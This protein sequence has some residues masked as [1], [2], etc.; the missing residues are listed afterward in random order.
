MTFSAIFRTK[1]FMHTKKLKFTLLIGRLNKQPDD[2]RAHTRVCAVLRYCV[3]VRVLVEWE[4]RGKAI[5]EWN[6]GKSKFIGI[7][8][9]ASRT[10]WTRR[11]VWVNVRVGW[12]GVFVKIFVSVYYILKNLVSTIGFSM[13]NPK[14]V[15]NCIFIGIKIWN[16]WEI[17]VR[18]K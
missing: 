7:A 16:I 10:L 5:N 12:Y 1:I 4:N 9:D 15:I 2:K 14:I 17:E 8:A 13:F 3:W 18:K 6:E 11:E